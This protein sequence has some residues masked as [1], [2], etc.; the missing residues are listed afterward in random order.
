MT[1]SKVHCSAVMKNPS[2]PWI[3]LPL[4]NFKDGPHSTGKKHRQGHYSFPAGKVG[5][6]LCERVSKSKRLEGQFNY[7]ACDC[8]R[9][10]SEKEVFMATPTSSC[11]SSVPQHISTTISIRWPLSTHRHGG[12][13]KNPEGERK[14]FSAKLP[15][16]RAPW[17]CY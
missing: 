5:G 14:Q 2:C 6:S 17:H 13:N 11:S 10:R 15:H 16:N 1:R 12:L 8:L 7:T 4:C 3:I 9:C